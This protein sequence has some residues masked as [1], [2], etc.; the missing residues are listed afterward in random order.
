MT[1]SGL[2]IILTAVLPSSLQFHR[3]STIHPQPRPSPASKAHATLLRNVKRAY[4]EDTTYDAFMSAHKRWLVSDR[5]DVR[6]ID[7]V[8]RNRDAGA[9]R[10]GLGT[11]E[12]SW[13]EGDEVLREVMRAEGPVCVRRKRGV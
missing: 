6:K 10:R 12:K 2:S 8:Y 1:A 3:A 9:A 7:S 4:G 11:L 13:G 5:V